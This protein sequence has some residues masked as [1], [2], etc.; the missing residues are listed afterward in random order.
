MYKNVLFPVDLA[1]ESSWKYA[2]PVTIEH[3][4]AFRSNLH[5]MT[6][7]PDSGMSIVS[8]YFSADAVKKVIE[9][10]NENL[11][12]FVKEHIPEDINTHKVVATGNV[13]E[14]IIGA[15]KKIG[16]DLIVMSAHRPE[17]KDYLLGPN[18]ARVVR[19]SDCSVLV[20]RPFAA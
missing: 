16:A 20:V 9:K 12:A 13:Y 5:V 11:H 17:L 19:H 8:Q 6:V 7:V 3:V 4:R 18:A 2:L 10:T 1:H 14:S 15:S